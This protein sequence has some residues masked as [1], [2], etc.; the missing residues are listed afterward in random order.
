MATSTVEDYLKQ[1]LLEQQAAGEERV[2]TGRIAQGLSVT[3]GTVTSMLKTLADGGLVD[4]EAYGGVRLTEAGMRLALHVLRRHRLVELFL[5]RVM[6]YDWS[7][8]HEEAELLEH[9]VSERLIE[10][11]DEMLGRPAVDPHGDPIPSAA[12]AVETADHP[13]LS[14]G[15]IGGRYRVARIADQTPHFLRLAEKL[16]LR[17]G[18]RLRLVAIDEAAD[19]LEVEL[20]RGRRA[21]LGLRAA[22][23][24]FV[25]RI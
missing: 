8:V 5:V 10:R 12:L 4:Y 6:K 7:E 19:T 24:V 22:A 13:P 17:P 21:S 23:K 16:G 25:E 3:P 18:R 15:E 20:E 1:I 14:A 9:A 2:S 11:M